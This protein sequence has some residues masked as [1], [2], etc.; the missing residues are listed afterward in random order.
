MRRRLRRIGC[1]D[2]AFHEGE[3]IMTDSNK[4]PTDR[5]FVVKNFTDKEGKEKGRWLEIGSVWPHKDG[6][7]FDVQLEADALQSG[8]TNRSP[9]RPILSPPN[10]LSPLPGYPAG[11]FFHHQR[12]FSHDEAQIS[13][14]FFV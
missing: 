6:K 10:R 7:G 13:S 5:A 9:R 8:L 12:S 14:G 4:K 11:A 1:N 3:N 2:A